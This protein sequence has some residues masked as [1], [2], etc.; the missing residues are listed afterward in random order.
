MPTYKCCI[1]TCTTTSKQGKSLF[2]FP[3]NDQ[4]LLQKWKSEI[5]ESQLRKIPLE[6][7]SVICEKHF[8]GYFLKNVE[9]TDGKVK[10]ILTPYAFPSIFEDEIED[11]ETSKTCRFCLKNINGPGSFVE[12]NNI[13]IRQF[14]IL[15]SSS[16]RLENVYSNVC[17]NKCAEDLK[18]YMNL[19]SKL[20]KNQDKLYELFKGDTVDELQPEEEELLNEYD[21]LVEIQETKML[22]DYQVP[23]ILFDGEDVPVEDNIAE[24]KRNF[25]L[26]DIKVLRLF[27]L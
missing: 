14:E 10:K 19:R 15:T 18:Y 22:P 11:Q 13:I 24:G 4:E 16:L 9:N 21:S 6:K 12:L 2:K 17:C 27:S 25:E 20:L 1:K 26:K 8:A 3:K 5:P 23:E 7:N